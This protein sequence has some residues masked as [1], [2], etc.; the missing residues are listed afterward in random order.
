MGEEGS[1][2]PGHRDVFLSICDLEN[3]VRKAVVMVKNWVLKGM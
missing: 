2:Q 1:A 3:S